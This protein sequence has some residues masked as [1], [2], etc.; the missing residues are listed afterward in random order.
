MDDYKKQLE[1]LLKKQKEVQPEKETTWVKRPLLFKVED[2]VRHINNRNLR[3]VVLEVEDGLEKNYPP[4][5]VQWSNLK[6]TSIH[7]EADLRLIDEAAER[8]TKA[9]KLI[10]E[11][12]NAFEQA[13]Q[14][15]RKAIN[16][17]EG[18]EELQDDS[19]VD[20]GVFEKAIENAGWQV[21]SLYC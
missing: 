4:L 21:S 8:A 16:L 7:F 2:K 1:E 13:F 12:T 15:W 3:G 14:A 19:L 10:N 6:W 5:L 20:V 18:V 9:Q 17:Y 11:A